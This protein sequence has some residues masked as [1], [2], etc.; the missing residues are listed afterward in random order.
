MVNKRWR[1]VKRGKF[2]RVSILRKYAGPNAKLWGKNAWRV[3]YLCLDGM[4]KTQTFGVLR[5]ALD[6]QRSFLRGGKP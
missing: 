5:W 4:E 2:G 3:E 6:S 1:R